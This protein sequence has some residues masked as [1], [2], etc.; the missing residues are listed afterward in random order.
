M[1]PLGIHVSLRYMYP[2]DTCIPGIH[3]SLGYMYP[4]GYMSPWGY[5]YPGD[6]CIFITI[7]YHP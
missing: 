6:T 4:W 2:W 1:Y 5:M 7:I 3:V